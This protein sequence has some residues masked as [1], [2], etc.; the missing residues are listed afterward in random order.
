MD[1]LKNVCVHRKQSS[2]YFTSYFYSSHS[3]Y[4]ENAVEL[5]VHLGYNFNTDI[6]TFNYIYYVNAP[7]PP[8]Y[9]E[10]NE[11]FKTTILGG[12][13]DQENKIICT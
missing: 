7:Q 13:D 6:L 2:G 12:C 5:P 9:L 1:K 11:D 8:K 10:L 3:L 4:V